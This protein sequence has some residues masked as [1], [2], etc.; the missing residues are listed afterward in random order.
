[1]KLGA[2]SAILL[3]LAVELVTLGVALAVTAR[4]GVNR[5]ANLYLAALLVV[6]AGLMTPFVLGYAGAYDTWPGLSFAPFSVP[7]A[8]GPLLYGHVHALVRGRG[9]GWRH[10]VLPGIQFGYQALLFPTSI[11]TKEWFDTMIVGP[12]VG[13]ALSAAVLA[14]MAAYAVA[15]WRALKGYERWLA[16]RRRQDRPARRIRA[17]ILL[18]APL[19][20]ARAG[21]TLFEAI[22]RPVNYFDLFGYYLLLGAVGVLL[23]V[24]GWRHAGSPAPAATLDPE[25]EWRERG[26]AW[27]AQLAGQGWWSDPGLDAA[28]LARRLATNVSHLSRALAPAGG[29]AVVV[30]RLRSEAVAEKIEAGCADD[31][32]G[33]ALDAGFGSKASFNR[34]FAKRFGMTPSAYRANVASDA[35]GA[36]TGN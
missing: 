14:S 26:E 12:Y 28:S 35:A 30:G 34:A 7:L 20:A 3:V 24:E 2:W 6:L 32:L 31:L 10:F 8:V 27:I 25:E 33:L 4:R 22:V 16:G 29:F 36:I 13:P 15:A 18:L 17:G 1:M 21:Y 5:A 23:G 9:I 19:V 11:E